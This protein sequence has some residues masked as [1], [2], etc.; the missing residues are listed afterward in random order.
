MLCIEFNLSVQRNGSSYVKFVWNK[1]NLKTP[2]IDM[3]VLG[4]NKTIL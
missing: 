1:L 4:K 2:I 3:G